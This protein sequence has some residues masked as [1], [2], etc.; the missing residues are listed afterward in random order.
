[1]IFYKKDVLKNVLETLLIKLQVFFIE[2]LQTAAS[3]RN[4]IGVKKN[5]SSQCL[6]NLSRP[7]LE[8]REEINLNFYFHTSL[9]CLK[10]FYE[11][12]EVDNYVEK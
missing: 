9:Q 10:R 5:P 1:M 7:A 6:F 2:D 12:L 4:Y 3:E 11:T 8:K